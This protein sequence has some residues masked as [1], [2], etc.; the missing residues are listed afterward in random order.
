MG[1]SDPEPAWL[2][3]WVSCLDEHGDLTD[4]HELG[5]IADVMGAGNVLQEGG[6]CIETFLSLHWSGGGGGGGY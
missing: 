2:A 5:V 1:C 6:D 3:V 4:A